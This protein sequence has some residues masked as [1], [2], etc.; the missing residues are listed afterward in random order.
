VVAVE[1]D[2]FASFN[3]GNQTGDGAIHVA[4]EQRIT[5]RGKLRRQKSTCLFR[6]VIAAIRKNRGDQRLTAQAFGERTGLLVFHRGLVP[7]R[8]R[9]FPPVSYWKNISLTALALL[10]PRV[11]R[12]RPLSRP[13]HRPRPRTTRCAARTNTRDCPKRRRAVAN[14]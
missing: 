10:R 2:R 9:S 1:Q 5:E 13:G 11:L 7:A 6:I 14:W 12:A 4:E 3:S 8:L